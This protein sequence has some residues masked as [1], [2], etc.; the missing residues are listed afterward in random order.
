MEER[1]A[2]YAESL[3]EKRT[4]GNSNDLVSF[5][6]GGFGMLQTFGRVWLV[7][8][9]VLADEGVGVVL[10]IEIAEGVVDFT[11]FTLVCANY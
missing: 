9:P 1:N 6:T 8:V 2:R 4:Q 11:M 5:P 3:E 7:W 10:L